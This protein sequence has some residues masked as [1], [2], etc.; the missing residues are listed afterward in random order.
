MRP[1]RMESCR[2][3]QTIIRVYALQ[4]L[5]T[6]LEGLISF[7][8]PCMLPMLPVY[9]SYFAGSAG[10]KQ[11]ILSRALFFVLGFTTV[12]SLLGLFAGTLGSFLSRYSTAV[13]IVCGM[14]VMIFGLSYLEVIRL[15]V[16]RGMRGG[17][18]INGIAS[19]FL[20]GMIYSVSLTPCV[21]A[22]L[23][24]ALMLASSSA[25]ALTGV[26]LLVVYSMGLGVPFIISA[27]LIDKLN[28]AF[29][30]IKAHYRVINLVCGGFLILVG[31]LM[32]FGLLGKLM[33]FFA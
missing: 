28:A 1:A 3:A 15:P 11:H 9:I 20:F 33:S 12:F 25:A 17:R 27:L 14:I 13:N 6:F 7:I 16:F 8:S 18:E 4:Y 10:R 30:F 23:G 5:I 24:S 19:A 21:G 31:L 2:A 26:L 22:F 29:G 32:C